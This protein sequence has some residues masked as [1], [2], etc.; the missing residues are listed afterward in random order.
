[1]FATDSIFT[2]TVPTTGAI[3]EKRFVSRTGALATDAQKAMGVAQDEALS[4]GI[5]GVCIHG[6]AVVKVGSTAITRGA[7][8]TSDAN[9]KARPATGT[10]P[11]NGYAF[12]SAPANGEV[13]IIITQ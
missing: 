1:M 3:S 6:L 12:E 10:E 7:T 8:I 4:G 11:V 13:R 9:G 2:L 5:V